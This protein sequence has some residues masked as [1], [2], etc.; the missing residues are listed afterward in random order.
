LPETRPIVAY[1]LLGVTIFIFLLQLL[2]EFVF[3]I[4]WLVQYG[5]KVNDRIA[6]GELWRLFTPMLLHGSIMHIAFN[7]YALNIFGP[8]LERFFG[9]G[10]FL[11]LYLLGGFGGN[12]L[13]MMFTEAP[14]LGSSTAIFGLLGAEGIF[15]YQNRALFGG[16]ARRALNNIITVALI[17]LLIGLTP[18]IDN[19]GHLGG[20]VAGLIFS[21]LGGPLLEVRGLPP[22]AALVDRRERSDILLAIAVTGGFF[23]LLAAG[24]LFLMK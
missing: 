20:L 19:W 22:C 7:M 6:A 16:M 9:H 12:V 14:S 24:A 23:G 13:S 15:L 18:G 10:R 17:N 5:V 4:D 1:S 11:I 8:R 3:G 21:W 2:S